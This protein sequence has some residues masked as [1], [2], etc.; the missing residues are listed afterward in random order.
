MNKHLYYCSETDTVFFVPQPLQALFDLYHP[1]NLYIE[2][3][4]IDNKGLV[5]FGLDPRPIVTYHS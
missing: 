4:R 5:H 2:N 3:P 1:E